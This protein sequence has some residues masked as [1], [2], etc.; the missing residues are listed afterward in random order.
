MFSNCI[1]TDEKKARDFVKKHR[2]SSFS[3]CMK[4][5][6]I[7][8]P[9]TDAVKETFLIG[10][11]G[12]PNKMKGKLSDGNVV[13]FN[14]MIA[15]SHEEHLSSADKARVSEI[16]SDICRGL[17]IIGSTERLVSG[18]L[19]CL[20][21]NEEQ[22]RQVQDMVDESEAS[23]VRVVNP[24]KFY[25]LRKTIRQDAN[26]AIRRRGDVPYRVRRYDRQQDMEE[27][28]QGPGKQKPVYISTEGDLGAKD[29]DGC[30]FLKGLLW[31][32]RSEWF[33]KKEWP[34]GS[35]PYYVYYSRENEDPGED[36]N[37]V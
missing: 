8:S 2:V 29:L 6:R 24:G 14:W 3:Q 28:L 37:P 13:V 16:A 10:L 35:G 15:Q 1:Y 20:E 12:F 4:I 19:A 30:E 21:R 26:T 17:R 18:V 31:I 5:L 23:G 11:N 22:V 25:S 34:H 27:Y 7:T 32:I 9:D 33:T 36:R